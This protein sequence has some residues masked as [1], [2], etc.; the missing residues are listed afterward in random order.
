MV[1]QIH[2]D[3]S[4]TGAGADAPGASRTPCYDPGRKQTTSHL[5]GRLLRLP[6]IADSPPRYSGYSGLVVPRVHSCSSVHAC[7]SKQEPG[8]ATG[9]QQRPSSIYIHLLSW[10]LLIT[11]PCLFARTASCFVVSLPIRA[12]QLASWLLV[13]R[14]IYSIHRTTQSTARAN[15][16]GRH[17]PTSWRPCASRRRTGGRREERRGLSAGVGWTTGCRDGDPEPEQPLRRREAC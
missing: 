15:N 5:P 1:H 9:R 6:V 10:T 17:S 14:S 3:V 11:F 16:G 8:G 13:V 12:S 4:V 2:C 7:S